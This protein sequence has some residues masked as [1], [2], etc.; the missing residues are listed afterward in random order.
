MTLHVV[1][2]AISPGSAGAV[3]DVTVPEA[4]ATLFGV[5][6]S[7]KI[8]RSK[9][10]RTPLFPS[11]ATLHTGLVPEQSPL[12]LPTSDPTAGIAVTITTGGEAPLRSTTTLHVPGQLIPDAVTVP[13]PAPPNGVVTVSVTWSWPM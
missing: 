4:P 7:G 2:Q 12:Q 1:P 11:M 8:W 13:M 9:L 3:V 5:T 10:G 6:V